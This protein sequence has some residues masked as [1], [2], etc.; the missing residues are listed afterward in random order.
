[1]KFDKENRQ[2][3]I[4]PNQEDP[5]KYSIKV[6][7]TQL[8]AE[9]IVLNHGDRILVGTHHYWLFTDPMIDPDATCDWETAM[10]E[11]NADSLKVMDQD[12]GEMEEIRKQAEAMKAERE[13]KE[14]EMEEQRAQFALLKKQQEEEL[15]AKKAE[16]MANLQHDA[17]ER[18]AME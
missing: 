9:P 3:T 5:E 4:Y 14:K 15:E 16:M 13:Q 8:A 18:A 11:A 6:N 1:M 12:N 2:V 7:G 17:A 10:K